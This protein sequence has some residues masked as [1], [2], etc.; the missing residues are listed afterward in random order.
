MRPVAPII[1]LLATFVAGHA[2]TTHKPRKPAPTAQPAAPVHEDGAAWPLEHLAV[3]GNQNFTTE[4]VL[5]AAQIHAGQSI[6]KKELE[7]VRQRL[8]DAGVFDRAGYRYAS[9]KDGK[10]YD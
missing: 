10:G 9:A 7:A 3:E 5:K 4:Q 1:L 8:L 2:Q 6:D